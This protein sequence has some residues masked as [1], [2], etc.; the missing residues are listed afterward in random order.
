MFHQNTLTTNRRSVIK[1]FDMILI[2]FLYIFQPGFEKVGCNPLQT[3]LP[4]NNRWNISVFNTKT[5]TI[6]ILNSWPSKLTFVMY[7]QEPHDSYIEC[8]VEYGVKWMNQRLAANYRIMIEDKHT[9]TTTQPTPPILLDDHVAYYNTIL[10]C[11]PVVIVLLL[12][13]FL[14]LSI[15]FL[16]R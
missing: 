9:Q 1:E 12:V 13:L 6:K 15:C 3:K 16:A 8:S 14:A 11:I 7:Y 4:T 2:N 10:I 5:N